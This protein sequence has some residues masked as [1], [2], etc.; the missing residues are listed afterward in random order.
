MASVNKESL[1]EEFGALQDRFAQL[2]ADGKI[3]AES[4]ALVEALLMLLKVI[5]AIHW[6][7]P[8]TT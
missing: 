6:Q 3:T 4:S 8:I 7:R 2:S 5:A 1:R